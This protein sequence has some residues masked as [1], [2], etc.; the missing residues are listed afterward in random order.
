MNIYQQLHSIVN[1]SDLRQVEALR[2][3]L[4]SKAE[5]LRF[6]EDVATVPVADTSDQSTVDVVTSAFDDSIN[7]V[8][9][10]KTCVDARRVVSEMTEAHR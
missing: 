9:L 3:V 1:K 2:L 7:K 4:E 5:P 8:G 6:D 10:I